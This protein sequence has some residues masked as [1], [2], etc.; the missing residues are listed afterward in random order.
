[1]KHTNGEQQLLDAGFERTYQKNC[2]ENWKKYELKVSL[3]SVNLRIY[4]I[5][6]NEETV[7]IPFNELKA[8]TTRLQELNEK[9]KSDLRRKQL[10]KRFNDMPKWKRKAVTYRP[11]KSIELNEKERTE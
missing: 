6:K 7:D 8:L 11:T 5:D 9:E 2:F 3:C 10:T 4:D 1:M